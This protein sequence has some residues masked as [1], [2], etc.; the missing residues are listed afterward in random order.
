LRAETRPHEAG[1][2]SSRV[3]LARGEYV[4]APCTHRP[5]KHPSEVRMRPPCG[6]RIWASQGGLSRNKVG[7]GE[8]GPGSPPTDRDWGDAPAHSS[9]L[10]TGMVMAG[11]LGWPPNC[12]GSLP[13]ARDR[14]I[15]RWSST[16]L[17]SFPGSIPGRSLP[18]TAIPFAQ[19][20]HHPAKA[21]LGRV[22]CRTHNRRV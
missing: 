2:G 15:A 18:R 7:L 6:G 9:C 3:S 20:M 21:W 13:L 8:S 1:F 4:P 5:S 14:P 10:R 17:R 12:Q 16:A 11:H 19:P 22:R